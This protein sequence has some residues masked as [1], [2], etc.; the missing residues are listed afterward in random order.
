M[1]ITI[2]AAMERGTHAH[3]LGNIQEADKF[4]TAVLN[5]QPTHPDANHNLGV[6]AVGIGKVEESLSFFEKALEVNPITQQYWLSYLNALILAKKISTAKKIVS[7]CNERGINGDTFNQLKQRLFELEERNVSK[8][9]VVVTNFNNPTKEEVLK[10][11]KIFSDGD[12]VE[13]EIAVK[14]LIQKFPNSVLL[15]NFLGAC[16]A[17][18]EK[19]DAAIDNYKKA[20]LINPTYVDSYSNLGSVLK[21]KGDLGAAIK[22]YERALKIKPN[23]SEALFNCANVQKLRGDFKAAVAGYKAAIAIKPEYAFAHLNL[24]ILLYEMGNIA[25][26]IDSYKHALQIKPDFPEAYNNLGSAL[27]DLGNYGP[28]IDSYNKALVLNPNYAEVFSNLGVHFME[29]GDYGASVINFENAIKFYPIGSK[30]LEN[31]KSLMLKS[32]YQLGK[33]DQFLQY[34]KSVIS[35]GQ[36]NAIIGSYS[37]RAELKFGIDFKNPFCS[38]PLDYILKE[39][40][41]QT[42]DFEDLFVK[43]A[44]KILA[45]PDI[46]ERKQGLLVNGYQTSG[47]LFARDDYFS[48]TVKEIIQVEIEKY[49]DKFDKSSE[50]LIKHFPKKYTLTA[51][52]VSMKSGGAIRPHMHESGWLSGSIYINVPKTTKSDDGNLVL[53]IDEGTE[54][55]SGELSSKI[56]DVYTGSLCLF[57]SSLLHYTLPFKSQYERIV[58]AFDV[59]PG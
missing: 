54:F 48:K 14:K 45:S 11:R 17:K 56:I 25:S 41:L 53:C 12:N 58:L 59:L 55:E 28:A 1:E 43:Q 52:L 4:Y 13:T 46:S 38:N 49:R 21:D 2:D 42:C 16:Q 31:V 29:H 10:L 9:N 23:F 19:F 51:W 47:N 39:S 30:K 27:R 8:E 44:K 32:L 35:S 57:P 36:V 7:Q 6:L 40:L 5:V 34:M 15:Y 24:G 50:G 22:S 20:I 3:K 33:E 26:A 37:C 18:Q